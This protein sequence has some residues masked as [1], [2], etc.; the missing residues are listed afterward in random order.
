MSDEIHSELGA[1]VKK[2]KE[3]F[4]EHNDSITAK[5]PEYAAVLGYVK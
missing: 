3:V 1:A 5:Y 2:A 4:A